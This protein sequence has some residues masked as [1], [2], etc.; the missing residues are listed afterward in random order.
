MPASLSD[1][2]LADRLSRRRARM[3]VP[4]AVIFIT[5]QATFFSDSANHHRTVSYVHAASWL[6][7]AAVILAALVTGGFW[8]KPRAVR[9]L[10]EDEITRAN[11]ARALSL[12]FVLA[13][14]TAML[15][16]VLD[17]FEPLPARTAIHLILS[18]GMGA[19]L[20][21]FAALERRALG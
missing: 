2:D 16:F 8:L 17:L 1:A 5:Q 15:L 19:A 21:R 11:R 12:G 7:L 10:M 9:A 3:I 14:V 20:L 4:L 18:V 13:M 6:V